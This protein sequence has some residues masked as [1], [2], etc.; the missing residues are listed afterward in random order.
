MIRSGHA[1]LKQDCLKTG[2][3]MISEQE[4]AVYKTLTSLGIQFTRHEHPPVFTVEEAGNYWPPIPGMHCK[5]LFL[6]NK[7]GNRHFLLIMAHSKR[8]DLKELSSLVEEDALSFASG[9]RLKKHLGLTAGSVS[10]YGLINDLQKQ[11]TV[12]IDMDLATDGV[13]YF[14]PNVNTATIGVERAD[15]ERFL[16]SCGNVVKRIRL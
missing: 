11:V 8:A 16:T 10:P 1:K 14:H 4:E 15:F 12:L 3:P 9:D 13:I 2:A 7:K 5:N 6:R